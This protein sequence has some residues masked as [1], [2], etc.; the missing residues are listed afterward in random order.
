MPVWF[1]LWHTNSQRRTE[2]TAS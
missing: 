2:C 1:N